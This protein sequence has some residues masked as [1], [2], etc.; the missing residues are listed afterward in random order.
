MKGTKVFIPNSEMDRTFAEVLKAAVNAG[1]NVL[2]YDS[3]V[4][5]NSISI[6]SRIGMN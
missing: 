5:E 1:V 4:D 3:V 2:V 6:G